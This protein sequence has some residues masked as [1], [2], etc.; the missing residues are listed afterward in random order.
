MAIDGVADDPAYGGTANARR[1]GRPR[2][3]PAGERERHDLAATV[4]HGRDFSLMSMGKIAPP[5]HFPRSGVWS[6]AAARLKSPV[7]NEGA[8]DAAG[9]SRGAF[10]TTSDFTPAAHRYR[11]ASPAV[12]LRVYLATMWDVDQRPWRMTAAAG[13]PLRVMRWAMPTRAECPE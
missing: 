3:A 2:T 4:T 8:I 9:T 1:R 7:L 13:A 12:S 5:R 10:V 6:G 11:R